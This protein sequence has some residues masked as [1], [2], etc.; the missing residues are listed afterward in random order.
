MQEAEKVEEDQSGSKKGNST[1]REVGGM[2][3]TFGFLSFCFYTEQLVNQ[4]CSVGTYRACRAN[5]TT[6]FVYYMHI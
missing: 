1:V 3:F 6:E 4:F 5:N 2:N